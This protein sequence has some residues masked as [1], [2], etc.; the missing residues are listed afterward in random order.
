MPTTTELKSRTRRAE[1]HAKRLAHRSLRSAGQPKDVG[2][3]LG[4]SRSTIAHEI[5]SRFNP[6]L[7]RAYEM[8]ILLNGHPG[9]NGRA[10]AEAMLEASE[11]TDIVMAETETLVS[12][13]LFL[14]DQED[15]KEGAENRA[16]K[17]GVDYSDALRAEASVQMELAAII[18]ELRTHERGSIDL[19]A[20]YRR[21]RR[22]A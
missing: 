10:V 12:R 17:A 22:D 11:L 14:L 7:K 19:L 13:G 4:K 8:T 18:D 15:L 9:T 1:S 3:A 5:T 20:V 21:T 6:E 16:A 2:R